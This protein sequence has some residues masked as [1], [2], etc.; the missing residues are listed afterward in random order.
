M[1]HE[2]AATVAAQLDQLGM[3][4]PR[5]TTG[6]SSAKLDTY[7]RWEEVVVVAIVIVIG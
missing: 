3:G 6:G 2:H 5:A 7:R 1:S 4:S